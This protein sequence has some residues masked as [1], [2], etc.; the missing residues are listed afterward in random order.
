MA[1][2]AA[3][4]ADRLRARFDGA[5]VTLDQPRLEVGMVLTADA[6][7]DG[8]HALRDEFGFEQLIDLCGVDYLGHG[9]DEWDTGVSSEGFSRGVQ[10][11]DTGRLNYGET[12]QEQV[13]QPQGEHAVSV[14]SQRFAV[15]VQLLSVQHNRRIRLKAF[16]QDDALPIFDSVTGVWPVANWF[17]REAFDLFGM[18]FSGHPDLRRILTDYGFI[19]HPFRKDFPLIG[20]VEVRYDAEQKRVIYEPVTSV[21]P[22]VLVPR[23]IR[24]D[25]RYATARGEDR[26]LKLGSRLGPAGDGV[27]GK[28]LPGVTQ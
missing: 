22:R 26:D 6:W 17:E 18:V 5:A 14:P 10:G 8:C 11:R 15:V 2:T 4:F 28:A 20:N 16:A 27:S 19:G 12:L 23:V 9:S 13:A 7:H 24:D 21:E 1:E 3:V 25:A